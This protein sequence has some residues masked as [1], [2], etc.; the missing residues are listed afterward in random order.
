[1]S[2]FKLK[3]NG[4]TWSAI[5]TA[6]DAKSEFV[7]SSDPWF[8]PVRIEN[9]PDGTLWIVDMYRY[10]I[11]HPEWIPE[12]W[13][14]RINVRAGDD[15]GRIYRVRR[16]DYTPRPIIDHKQLPD[17]KLL[18]ELIGSDAARADLAQQALV[19]RAFESNLA[20]A[21]IEQIRDVASNFESYRARVRALHLLFTMGKCTDK[22]YQK[23]L[24]ACRNLTANRMFPQ[25]G[26]DR[27]F[28]EQAS[29]VEAL[30]RQIDRTQQPSGMRALL[31]DSIDPKLV[32]HSASLALRLAIESSYSDTPNTRAIA[33]A[34]ALHGQDPWVVDCAIFIAANSV[35]GVVESLL[36]SLSEGSIDYATGVNHL[37][38]KLI[39]KSSEELRNR[40]LSK[41]ATQTEQ[42][43]A[44][45]YLLARQFSV[46]SDSKGLESEAVDRLIDSA[47]K[48][49]TSSGASIATRFAAMELV[50]SQMG[51]VWNRNHDLF[52]EELLS[53]TQNPLDAELTRNLLRTGG[54]SSA[55]LLS[56]WA[57][58][59]QTSRTVLLT[60]LSRNA[61]TMGRLLDAVE[62]G[63]I[64]VKEVDAATL[65]KLRQY[66]KGAQEKQVLALFG[67]A[68]GADRPAI[69]RK[70]L[71]QWP[72]RAKEARGIESDVGVDLV[73]G[74]RA[75]LKHC[76]VCHEP[77]V[78]GDQTDPSV[79]PNLLGLVR[80]TNE[81]WVTA[82]LDPNR[83]VEEKYWV[84]QART[85]D[86]ELVTGLRLREDSDA[87]EW[88][89][90]AGR[91][92]R[93]LKSQIAELR[94]SQQS[95]MPEG[96]EQLISTDEIAD[97]ISFLRSSKE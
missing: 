96:F 69:V 68:P 59:S 79:G 9:A 85:E 16:T 46:G 92:D 29:W 65:Q 34:L 51:S 13:Q 97:I 55:R 15:R 72:V 93:L 24:V 5:R 35:D 7:R 56:K 26:S 71:E 84:F 47:R 18:T 4:A 67:P 25:D 78:H 20:A 94:E 45:H 87:I 61:D 39:P 28:D 77:R 60:E 83:S 22:D 73:R 86:G 58:L 63:G 32:V 17:S 23:M 90:N 41:V 95:L 76:A 8:R 30:V 42:H 52:L 3:R 81:A 27:E 62:A 66:A 88:V 14:R 2:R 74:E 75:Y 6:E 91:I 80:W 50:L 33:S 21:T 12:E 40:L 49:I 82:I 38:E 10:V 36:E 57:S 54:E 44:W 19:E 64:P 70:A 53:G 43:P 89:N 37:V 48:E 11:E 31:W 1:V